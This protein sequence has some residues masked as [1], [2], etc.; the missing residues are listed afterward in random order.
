MSSVLL[1]K[2]N[3]IV[4]QELAIVCMPFVKKMN[5]MRYIPAF[6]DVS[7][8]SRLVFSFSTPCRQSHHLE[9]KKVKYSSL[10]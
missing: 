4:H 8:A 1:E 10:M 2:T 7:I 6:V 9:R 3:E 5:T